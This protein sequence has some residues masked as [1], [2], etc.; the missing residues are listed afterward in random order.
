M[1]SRLRLL[2]FSDWTLGGGSGTPQ[3]GN[4]TVATMPY[5]NVPGGQ[6]TVTTYIFS[7]TVPIDSSKAVASVTLPGSVNQ[8]SI[9]IFAIATG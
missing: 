4:V 8:G 9:G 5:R 2:G 1:S 7:Q 6:H 3:L